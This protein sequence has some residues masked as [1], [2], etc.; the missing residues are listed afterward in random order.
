M[1]VNSPTKIRSD[2]SSLL[3]RRRQRSFFVLKGLGADEV[4]GISRSVPVGIFG[5]FVWTVRHFR[6]QGVFMKKASVAVVLLWVMAFPQLCLAESA[7][8]TGDQMAA[9]AQGFSENHK[10][11]KETRVQMFELGKALGD[12]YIAMLVDK[13]EKAELITHYGASLISFCAATQDAAKK[14]CAVKTVSLMEESKKRMNGILKELLATQKYVPYPPALELI[15]RAKA[16]M[17]SSLGLMDKA[18]AAFQACAK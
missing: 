12:I 6:K 3:E 7:K 1:K 4:S 10:S 11:L 14:D 2:H 13:T 8:G 15:G 16:G 5:V 18:I 9:L 17:E